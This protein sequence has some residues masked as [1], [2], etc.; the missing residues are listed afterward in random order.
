MTKE[1][2]LIQNSKHLAIKQL[3]MQDSM[4]QETKPIKSKGRNG[5]GSSVPA[6]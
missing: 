2:E 6:C 5:S 1:P 4:D 3:L